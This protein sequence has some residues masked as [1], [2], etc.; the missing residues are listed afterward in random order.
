MITLNVFAELFDWDEKTTERAERAGGAVRSLYTLARVGKSAASPLMFVEAGMAV[1]DALGAYAEFRQAKSKTRE[2]EAEGEALAQA[3]KELE[4]Q[5]RMQ[6]K[7]RE[8]KFTAQMRTTRE[9][10]EAQDIK[11]RIGVM[12]LESFSRQIKKLGKHIAAQRLASAPNCVPL[13]KLE[14]AYYQLVDAQLSATLML[15]ED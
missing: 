3:L 8:L 13:L 1:L 6:T 2:L 9:Q 5:F 7:L 4:K 15:M 12:E 11:L 14:R 10:L